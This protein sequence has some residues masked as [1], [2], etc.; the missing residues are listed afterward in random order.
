M[1]SPSFDRHKPDYLIEYF[2]LAATTAPTQ[3]IAGWAEAF[4]AARVGWQLPRCERLLREAKGWGQAEDIVQAQIL[5]SEGLL[6]QQLGEWE[7]AERRHQ[8]ALVRFHAAGHA[9]GIARVLNN[10]ALLYLETGDLTR[11]T[12]YAEASLK[13]SREIGN[14]A[15]IARALG[16]LGVVHRRRESWDE[17]LR[18]FDECLTLFRRLGDRYN[19]GRTLTN[20]GNLYRAQGRFEEALTC[21]EQDLTICRGLSD[22]HGEAQALSNVGL[23][24]YVLRRWEQARMVR[25]YDP[26]R[27]VVFVFLGSSL[28]T[29]SP[30][31]NPGPAGSDLPAVHDSELH[32][33]ALRRTPGL[34]S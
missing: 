9:H 6:Q 2:H 34:R 17:A 33:R 16:N 3:A 25:E 24:Q 14:E 13:L 19:E 32:W 18:C 23:A 27:E 7:E 12:E 4:E 21:Y 26:E 10:L 1:Q 20:L 11:A 31:S 22:R 29:S 15:D 5:T 28:V 30:R 8:Q